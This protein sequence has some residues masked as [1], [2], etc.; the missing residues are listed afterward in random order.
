MTYFSGLV[1]KEHVSF[2]FKNRLLV[3]SRKFKITNCQITS[4][5]LTAKLIAKGFNRGQTT[6]KII[7]LKGYLSPNATQ[8][9]IQQVAKRQLPKER[10]IIP[11]EEDPRRSARTIQGEARPGSSWRLKASRES[12]TIF[13]SICQSDY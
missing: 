10:T 13:Q 3:W 12:S 5:Q 9:V 1:G 2:G 8:G 4:L 7:A 6:P 11:P